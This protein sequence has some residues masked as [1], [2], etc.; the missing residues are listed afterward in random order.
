MDRPA[1]NRHRRFYL[2]GLYVFTA[3]L[4]AKLAL[5]TSAGGQVVGGP[6][7]LVGLMFAHLVVADARA[8]GKPLP[9]F[10]AWQLSLLGPVG[11]AGCVIALRKGR[12]VLYV[13][14]HGLL[15]MAVYVAS[16]LLVEWLFA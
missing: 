7:L 3:L 8:I 13:A 12:G 4:G 1:I 9:H 6:G 11:A 2:V 15:L 10:A 16:A 5:G 14:I